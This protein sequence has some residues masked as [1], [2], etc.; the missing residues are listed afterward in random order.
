MLI[1][2]DN[3]C[4]YENIQVHIL[5]EVFFSVNFYDF[6]HI[7]VSFSLIYMFLGLF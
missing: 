6:G 7:Y 1:L 4:N 5:F 2:V 3:W